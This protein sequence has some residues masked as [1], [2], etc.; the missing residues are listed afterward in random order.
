MTATKEKKP[1]EKLTMHEAVDLLRALNVAVEDHVDEIELNG[2]ALPDWM[3]SMFDEVYASMADR[4]DAL[5]YVI[6]EMKGSAAASKATKDRAGRRERV[7]SN[8]VESIKAY[9][10]R[11]VQASGE[12]RIKGTTC[13]LRI[14]N[15][16]QPSTTCTL[17]PEQLVEAHDQ[18]G[19]L[20]RFITVAR[21]AT[22][23][24]RA[25]AVAYEARYADLVTESQLIGES[26]IE[27]AWVE[28]GEPRT[29]DETAQVLDQ[30]RTIYIRDNLAAEFPGVTVVRG[31]HLRID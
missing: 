5:A 6:D 28:T 2:G 4:A 20:E 10:L 16:S 14:Q 30:M 31:I 25:L 26:D 8:V 27:E 17:T 11:E 21:V 12:D 23:D 9:A 22:L 29:P 15:N 7:W 24:T 19:P 3:A 13:V 18:S 1:R